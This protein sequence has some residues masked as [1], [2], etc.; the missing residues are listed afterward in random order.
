M[1]KKGKKEYS[2][3]GYKHHQISVTLILRNGRNEILF[4][5]TKRLPDIWQP[6]GGHVDNNHDKSLVDAV[7]RE[8]REEIGVEIDPT[9]LKR[10]YKAPNDIDS[11]EIYFFLADMPNNSEIIL[12]SQEILEYRW[13]SMK[14]TPTIT[15][16]PATQKCL[17]ILRLAQNFP[18]PLKAGE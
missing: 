1:R 17:Q 3:R 18:T 10:I 2:Y 6:T 12:N 8:T 15:L 16:L 13:V 5:R 14:D 9:T 7:L 4:V 11:G